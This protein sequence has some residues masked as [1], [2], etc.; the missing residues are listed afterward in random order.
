MLWPLVSG[1]AASPARGRAVVEPT[2]R[3][4]RLASGSG[5]DLRSRDWLD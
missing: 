3:P 4:I 5:F 2:L 1:D